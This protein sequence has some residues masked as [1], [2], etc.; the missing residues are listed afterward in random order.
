MIQE[1]GGKPAYRSFPPPYPINS[2][3]PGSIVARIFHAV[4]DI[5]PAAV[6]VRKP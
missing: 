2:L 5:V 4:P 1:A 3:S 6:P